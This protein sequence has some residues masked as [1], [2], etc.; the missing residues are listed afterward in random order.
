VSTQDRDKT[1]KPPLP[2]PGAAPVPVPGRAPPSGARDSPVRK[3]LSRPHPAPQSLNPQPSTEEPKSFPELVLED[4][5]ALRQRGVAVAASPAI[6]Y[7][8]YDTGPASGKRLAQETSAAAVKRTDLRKLSDWIKAQ[9]RVEDLKKD[10]EPD[11]K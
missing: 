3:P 8:P 10:D 1:G 6:G 2:P 9:R 11:P 4:T 7:N 5:A